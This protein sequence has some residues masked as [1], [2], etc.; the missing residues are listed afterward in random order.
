AD[1]SG[2]AVGF[3]GRV[4]GNGEPKYLNSGESEVFSKSKLLYGLNWAKQSIRKADRL[5]VVEGYF[6]AI[7]LMA[8]GIAEV[9][10]PMGT[11]LTELQAALIGKYTKNVFLLYDSDNAGLKATFGSGDSLLKLGIAVRVISLPEGEDPDSY[12]AKFGAE[13]F[14]RAAKASVDVFERKIQMLERGGWFTDL[15]RKRKALDKLLPTIRVTAD[16]LTRDLYISR[17]CET[18]GVSREQL[19]RELQAPARPV[20][21]PARTPASAEHHGPPPDDDG[22]PIDD[23]GFPIP[24]RRADRRLNRSAI[25]VRAERELI[26]MLLHHRRY[27]EVSAER[28]GADTFAD[29]V[30]RSIFAELTARE[31]DVPIEELAGALD[32]E[33]TEVLQEL[34][35]ENG[36]LDRAEETVN[37]SINALLSREISS[38]LQEIDRL[39]PLA[40][41]D[42]K[43]D[44]IREKS[45]LAVEI[46]ALGR[47][48][49]KSFN[50][51]RS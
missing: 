26:R 28:I 34:M 41:S 6:D 8:A 47:P 10:A 24:V 35:N 29:P 48:R 17:T 14:E 49:W 37:G 51:S 19:E 23:D 1:A 32:E 3:G 31:S 4:M 43:D 39:L 42:K 9:V 15:S 16:G 27:V 33:A 36:G 50:S 40:D 25:G 20:R 2:H 45:R 12:V 30:Y 21:T 7:R 22:P 5:I 38:R 46:A 13:G 18:A 11:A 44:L